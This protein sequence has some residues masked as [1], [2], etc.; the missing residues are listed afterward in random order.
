MRN[1]LYL[2]LGLFLITSYSYSQGTRGSGNV[3]KKDF[4]VSNI[5]KVGNLT[6]ANIFITQSESENLS[7]EIDDNLF[8]YLEY[9]SESGI[10]IKLNGRSVSPTKFN[11]YVNVKD[12][13]KIE[14]TG[15]GNVSSTNT[16]KGTSFKLEQTGSGNVDLNLSAKEFKI[17]VTG[18]GNSTIKSDAEFCKAEH[19]GSGDI[20]LKNDNVKSNLKI[21]H[22]GSGNVDVDV[23]G[24]NLAFTNTGSGDGKITGTST[25]FKLENDGSGNV[26]GSAFTTDYCNVE[27][28][29]SGDAEFTCNKEASIEINGSGDLKLK[30]EYK[31]KNIE[32]NGSGKLIK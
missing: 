19:T 26:T 27:L 23:K 18:S 21:E 12:L 32:M 25:N 13:K 11:V 28:S 1:L 22:T 4:Q 3:V 15:S 7:V 5:N 16:I 31:I 8:Q 17:E 6:S 20:S 29:G 9:K 14:N 24:I 30:G 2:L 10:E